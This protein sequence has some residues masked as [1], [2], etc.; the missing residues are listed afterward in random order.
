MGVLKGVDEESKPLPWKDEFVY[1]STELEGYVSEFVDTDAEYRE[2]QLWRLK[3]KITAPKL[4][5]F[6]K[7]I[8]HYEPGIVMHIATIYVEQ[9]AKERRE[10]YTYVGPFRIMRWDGGGH[11]F[12]VKHRTCHYQCTH[13]PVCK[14]KID[15]GN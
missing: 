5:A 12:C 2:Q 14:C 15:Y 10:D 9:I 3:N 11:T 13:C 6:I 1:Y 4:A 7:K 8:A